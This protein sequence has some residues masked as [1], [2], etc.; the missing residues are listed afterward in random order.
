MA[1]VPWFPSTHPRWG[2]YAKMAA[3]PARESR[4]GID[5]LHPRYPVIPKV[6][7]TVAPALLALASLAPLRRLTAEGFDF[8]LIDA[9]YYYPD[10]VAAAMLARY[11]R[12]RLVVTARGSDIN[13]I[14]SYAIAR[15]LMQWAARS[16]DASIAVCNDL[17]D[18]IKPWTD[19]ARVHVVRNGVDLQRFRPMSQP[20][21]RR[22]L[23]IDASPLLLSVGNLV[24]NKGHALVIDA[25]ADVAARFPDARV[26][27]STRP[28]PRAPPAPR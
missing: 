15:R 16:A 17:A 5:V 6:G 21:A 4:N 20:D 10:G 9:H 1:P 11:F 19:P 7:M 26:A 14:S 12:K 24:E 27:I 18:Q 8:D 23:K 22:K 3:T 13:Q 28:R 2:D 25:L